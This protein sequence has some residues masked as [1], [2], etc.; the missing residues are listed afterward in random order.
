[1]AVVLEEVHGVGHAAEHLEQVVTG[2]VVVGTGSTLDINVL[3]DELGGPGGGGS[4]LRGIGG[5][6]EAMR[7]GASVVHGAL[8]Q[9]FVV[10]VDEA[11]LDLMGRIVEDQARRDRVRVVG[12]ARRGGVGAV[13]ILAAFVVAV[14]MAVAAVVAGAGA[15]AAGAGPD[16]ARERRGQKRQRRGRGAA[17]PVAAAAVLGGSRSTAAG[18]RRRRRWRRRSRTGPEEQRS[19][20]LGRT[21]GGSEAGIAL[22][23]RLLGRL[24]HGSN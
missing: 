16:A 2:T 23:G 14:V 13:G 9:G 8:L 20:L 19:S 12:D 7:V 17:A 1:M 15:A 10:L 3:Q 22:G 24:L 11:D 4:V 6:V 5:A 21:G 18:G